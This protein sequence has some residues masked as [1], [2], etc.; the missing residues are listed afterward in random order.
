R[1]WKSVA[2]SVLKN[3]V[4]R[5]PLR[6][7]RRVFQQPAKVA[8][9]AATLTIACLCTSC[10]TL[11][12]AYTKQVTWTN[13]PLV[14]VVTN[15]VIATNTV[16]EVVQRTNE[17]ATNIVTLLQTNLVPVFYT[18]LVQVPVTNLVAKPEV[19]ATIGAAGSIVNTVLPG[20]GSIMALALGGLY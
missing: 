4:G 12:R 3:T 13:A 10:G 5:V 14:Q 9:L 19:L 2:N 7:V 6:G 16:I 20:V 11:D 8:M 15:T 18:N 17:V 1:S